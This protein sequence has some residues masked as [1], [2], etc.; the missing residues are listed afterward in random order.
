M[1]PLIYFP[2]FLEYRD[3]APFVLRVV[4]GLT[5]LYFGCKKV[6]GQGQSSGSNSKT[7]GAMEI[8]V[9]I[10][11][12]VGLFTQLAVLINFIILLIKIIDKI[13]VKKFLTDGVNYYI[14][15]FV[16]ALSLL[17]SGPGILAID[18]LF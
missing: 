18:R 14:L 2:F 1:N 17:F 3:F 12:T 13:R 11:I 4:L 7:F 10:F 5:L 6:K 15:L 8:V 16:I 9:A